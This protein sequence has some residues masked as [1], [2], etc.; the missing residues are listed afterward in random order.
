MNILAL[1]LGTFTG[2]AF[3]HGDDFQCGTWKLATPTEVKQWGKERLTR[4]KDPRI[5]R[6]CSHLEELGTFDVLVFE[7]VFFSTYTQQTQIWSSLRASVWLCGQAMIMECVPVTT[8][9]KWAT[10]NGAASKDMMN[11]ALKIQHPCRW[12][13]ILGED[14]VDAIWIW[15]WARQNYSRN[16]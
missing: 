10:G 5:K 1:D 14:T 7:D 13:P 6:L 15:L 4:R 3:N 16:K 9:K 11:N 2:Y 12:T 8:L